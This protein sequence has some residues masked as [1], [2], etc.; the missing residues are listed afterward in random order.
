VGTYLHHPDEN[1]QDGTIKCG[2]EK[3]RGE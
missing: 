3:E 2:P 1:R